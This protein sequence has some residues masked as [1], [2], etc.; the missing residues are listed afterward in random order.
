MIHR[1]PSFLSDFVDPHNIRIQQNLM[2]Q[3]VLL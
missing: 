2:L 1:E 3:W